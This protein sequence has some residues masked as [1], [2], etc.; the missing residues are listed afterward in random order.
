MR[1]LVTLPSLIIFL[2][3]G[4]NLLLQAMRVLF[5]S[6]LDQYMTNF[7]SLLLIHSSHV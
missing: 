6:Y 2:K 5:S 7:T 4:V 1:L 3:D